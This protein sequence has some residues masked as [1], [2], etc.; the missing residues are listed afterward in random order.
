MAVQFVQARDLGR[1][2]GAARYLESAVRET[3]EA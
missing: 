1:H 3:L 2:E